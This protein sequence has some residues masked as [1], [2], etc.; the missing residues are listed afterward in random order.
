MYHNRI[1]DKHCCFKERR[2]SDENDE[3]PGRPSTNRNAEKVKVDA[4]V[5]QTK[6]WLLESFGMQ[7][8]ISIFTEAK[9]VGC[10]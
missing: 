1:S 10:N 7:W 4:L 9:F 3:C 5:K 2:T 6:D 8:F